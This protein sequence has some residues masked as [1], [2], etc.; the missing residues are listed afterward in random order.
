MARVEVNCLPWKV[1][2]SMRLADS[3]MNFK[4]VTL[5]AVTPDRL[6]CTIVSGTV[7]NNFV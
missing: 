7:V 1:G 5:T 6:S 2:E 3:W 4:A